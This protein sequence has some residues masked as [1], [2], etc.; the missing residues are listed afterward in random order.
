MTAP[1]PETDPDSAERWRTE[2]ADRFAVIVD[3]ER[4]FE[5]A[6]EAL[7]RA[8]KRIM[9][10]GWDFDARIRLSGDARLPGE[11][12]AIGDFLYWLVERNPALELYL[13]RWDTGA[14]KSLAHGRTLLTI[15]KWVRHPRIH[16]RLDSH[17]PFAS[18]H[19][20]KI[21]AID[22][23]M[24]FCGGID[25]TADRWDTRGHRD[26]EPGR[27]GP[28]G[29]PYA[30]WHDATTA[31]SGPVAGALA[32]L[33][34]TRWRRA[35]GHVLDPV[36]GG[37]ECWPD[38]LDADFSD[39]AITIARTFPEMPNEPAVHEIERLF[40]AQIG[41]ATRHIYIESQYFASR[42]I[43]EAIARRLDE[44][45]GPEIVLINPDTAEG[46][47]QPI[48][49]D[50]AR[51]RLWAALQRR[52]V[53]RRLA[54]YHPVTARRAP[55]YVHAKI[56]VIDDRELRIGSANVNN[57]SMRLDTECDVVV[58][59]TPTDPA[60][61]TRI[62][63][64][65]DGL[66]AEHLGVAPERVAAEIA[67]RG[68]LIAAIEALRCDARSLVRY[69]VP[70]LPAIEAWLAD[71]EVL[72]PEGPAEMFEPFAGRSLFRGWFRRR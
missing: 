18:S 7:L 65:R 28:T 39:V 16:V 48:A 6:R 43:A 15:L 31:L 53:H 63:A 23:R 36:A 24:A 68:S 22:D 30:P 47:L 1:D 49:M 45:D 12:Q 35:S 72:D 14:L 17:H 67:R 41:R 46:W 29:R 40:V 26:D 62:V 25:M 52:D 64:I 9:L 44:P 71:N 19:H 27:R 4:Y 60:I 69:A 33:C 55:I 70:D 57:R 3:A 11:P 2:R 54:M 61:A 59:A 58:A 20:Q 34:R 50:T 66:I 56:M 13:L 5:V 37:A 10:V 32:E 21:V 8:R 38:S 51:A 42:V